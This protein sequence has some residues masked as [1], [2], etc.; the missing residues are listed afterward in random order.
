MQLAFNDEVGK[1][2]VDA[3]ML[4]AINDGKIGEFRVR[5]LVI[6]GIIEGQL[7]CLQQIFKFVFVFLIPSS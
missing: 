5:N 6:D 7:L 2:E 1:S 3:L 4:E